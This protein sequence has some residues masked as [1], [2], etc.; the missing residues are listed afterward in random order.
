MVALVIV[1]RASAVALLGALL[2]SGCGLLGNDVE[3]AGDL[4]ARAEQIVAAAGSDQVSSVALGRGGGVS[5]AVRAGGKD[6]MW[7]VTADHEPKVTD[8]LTGRPS[9]TIAVSQINWQQLM[10]WVALADESCLSAVVVMDVLPHGQQVA[11][12]AC[13]TGL[14]V[15]HAWLDGAEIPL[16]ISGDDAAAFQQGLDLLVPLIPEG[17][18]LQF[19]KGIQNGALGSAFWIDGGQ[20]ELADG[21]QQYYTI[22]YVDKP[23]STVISAT[24]S[25][26]PAFSVASDPTLVPPP[27]NPRDYPASA[28]V[29]AVEEGLANAPYPRERAEGVAFSASPTV[30]GQVDYNVWSVREDSI[31]VLRG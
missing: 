4:A 25:P 12:V 11:T 6:Q 3:D 18:L 30:P 27:F 13:Q 8:D 26:D 21:S 9:S 1:R 2:L 20:W 15:T 5:L 31:G 7:S 16:S 17:E 19:A 24:A 14:E 29:A 28:Y 10:D 23:S 22:R